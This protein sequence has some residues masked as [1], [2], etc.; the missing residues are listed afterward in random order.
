MDLARE[1]PINWADEMNEVAAREA[2]NAGEARIPIVALGSHLG[3][4]SP[5]LSFLPL[6][7][8]S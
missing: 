4:A 6:S 3:E 8:S 5:V 2:A 1:G 7:S